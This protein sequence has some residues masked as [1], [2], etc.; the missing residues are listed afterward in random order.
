MTLSELNALSEEQATEVFRQCCAS[1]HWVECMVAA[2]PFANIESLLIAS[3]AVWSHCQKSDYL[4][5]F[6][7][8][9]KI[10]DINSLKEKYANTQTLAG[11]EQSRVNEANEQT[12]QALAE[13]NKQYENRFGYIFIVCATGKTAGEMLALLEQRLGNEPADEVSI[14]AS[15]QHKI[16]RIRLCK[17]L[18]NAS[19]PKEG[20]IL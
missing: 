18:K 2:R 15:E 20:M 16:T 12:L 4:E 3:D 14:A 19:L 11:L 5:A 1:G 9:P 13:G 17:M 6:D 10:G 8:H 7:A